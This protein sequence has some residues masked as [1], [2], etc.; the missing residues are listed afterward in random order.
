MVVDGFHDTDPEALVRTLLL[1]ETLHIGFLQQFIH[2][3]AS[4]FLNILSASSQHRHWSSRGMC[5]VVTAAIEL[6]AYLN[7][8]EKATPPALSVQM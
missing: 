7:Y 3:L 4:F 6:Y 8:A 5:A 2:V 1:L